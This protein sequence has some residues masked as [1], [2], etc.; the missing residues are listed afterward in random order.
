MKLSEL[1]GATTAMRNDV[2][3]DVLLGG[4]LLVSGTMARQL[5]PP[6][7]ATTMK[8]AQGGTTVEV[9]WADGMNAKVASSSGKL[10]AALDGLNSTLPTT[11]AARLDAFA[12]NLATQVNARHADGRTDAGP[13]GGDIFGPPPGQSLD[14]SNIRMLITSPSDLA[15]ADANAPQGAKDGDNAD[16]LAELAKK[17]DG[18]DR[19]YRQLVVDLGA[20]SQSAQRRAE[21]QAATVM[22][23]DAQRLSQ[24][25]VNLDEEMSN[26]VQFERSYQAAAKVIST[27]DEM[28]DV[29]INRM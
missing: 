1:T 29:L 22:E 26:L 8:D 15:M 10:A 7:G 18:P 16:W 19:D 12:V 24:S 20:H 3:V 28:L 23:V 9:R 13:A 25:G 21:I 5:L 6:S 17:A 27:I 2:S 14:A 11:Y 4:S